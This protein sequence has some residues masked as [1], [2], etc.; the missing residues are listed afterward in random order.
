MDRATR[1]AR[2]GGDELRNRVHGAL[3]RSG[4]AMPAQRVERSDAPRDV[5]ELWRSAGD[6]IADFVFARGH[7]I[8]YGTERQA[9]QAQHRLERAVADQTTLENLGILPTPILGPVVTALYQARPFLQS[10]T[11]RPMPGGG[12]TFSRPIVNQHTSVGIQATEKTQLASRNMQIDPLQVSKNTYG[13]ALDISFQDRDWTDPAIL[14]IVIDDLASQYA[15]DT[16][17]AGATAFATAVTKTVP[18]ADATSPAEWLGAIYS[19]AAAVAQSVANRLPDTLWASTDVWRALGMLSDASGRPLFPVL[20]PMNADGQM[21]PAQWSANPFGLRLVVDGN[22][23]AKTAIVGIASYAEYYE[24]IGGTVSVTEPS[25]LG[26]TVAYYGYFASCV[27]FPDAFR[28]L[29]VTTMPA[30]FS[31]DDGNGNGDDDDSSSRSSRSKAS[32]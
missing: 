5:T 18:L 10:I 29:A 11:N 6:Y 1:G 4:Q 15:L 3:A 32:A 28:K 30:G 26:Y 8:G 13:G 20:G 25:I 21:N 16:D 23:P 17:A 22:L 27:P 31:L 9:E 12:K 2:G 14:Q 7:D 19:A 24:Q